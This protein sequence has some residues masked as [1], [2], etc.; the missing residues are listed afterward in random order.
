MK[1]N[2]ATIP[3]LAI[4]SSLKLIGDILVLGPLQ[5]IAMRVRL[6][7]E[8]LQ[9]HLFGVSIDLIDLIRRQL[10]LRAPQPPIHALM[11]SICIVRLS[12]ALIT[13]VCVLVSVLKL[14]E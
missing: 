14:S 8:C 3:I 2:T 12:Y 5:V 10:M 7:I 1:D 9:V 11:A 6:A 4:Y 13:K